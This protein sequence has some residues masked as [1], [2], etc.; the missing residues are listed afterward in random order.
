[1]RY[2]VL[3][4]DTHTVPYRHQPKKRTRDKKSLLHYQTHHGPNHETL[5]TEDSK[6]SLSQHSSPEGNLSQ[7]EVRLSL[8]DVLI[9]ILSPKVLQDNYKTNF[10]YGTRLVEWFL[11]FLLGQFQILCLNL[12]VFHILVRVLA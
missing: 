2:L 10:L 7:Q 6:L 5:Q 4:G 9:L 3:A 11:K 8:E 1:M 12:S